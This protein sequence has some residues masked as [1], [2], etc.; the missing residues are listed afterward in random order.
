MSLENAELRLLAP[1]LSTRKSANVQIY[2]VLGARRRRFIQEQE[3]FFSPSL[4]KWCEFDVTDVVRNWISGDR[5]LG[6]ELECPGCSRSWA[7]LEATISALIRP[8]AGRKR[9][10]IYEKGRRTDCV[11]N[12]KRKCCRHTMTVTFK[13]LKIPEMDSIIQPKY[14]EAGFCRGRCPLNYNHATN[15]S[16][17]QS[18][19]HRLD[20]KAMP[21][22]CCAPSKLEPL[23][24]LRINPA[25][26]QKLMIEKW[27]NMKVVECAC[28]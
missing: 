11:G 14:Y 3:I 27:D 20:S 2:Q 16:R 28:S 23:E 15:H 22:V 18:L 24:I 8:G 25:D 17:I 9:R 21:K 6:L 13:N 4:N 5:N 12:R 26:T 7:P 1:P 19:M 10:N